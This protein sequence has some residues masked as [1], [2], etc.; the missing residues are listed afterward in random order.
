MSD[1]LVP[2]E[3]PEHFDE[4]LDRWSAAK[5]KCVGWC[6]LCD[7]AIATEADLIP[8][9]DTHNCPKGRALEAASSLEEAKADTKPLNR[10]QQDALAWQII[11]RSQPITLEAATRRRPKDYLELEQWLRDGV[12]FEMAWS[13]FLHAF[14]AAKV[15]SFFA[16]PSP[17]SLSPG[18]QAIVAGSAEW[19]SAEFGLP[20]PAWTDD[21]KYFLDAPW[22]PWQELG[23]DVTDTIEGTLARSPEAFRKRNVAFL[24]RNLIT[25]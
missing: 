9:T 22:D 13:E 4:M 19:L 14:F 21:P 20:H 7:R 3:F 6:L 12:G 11:H 15:A 18:W 25:L 5:D 2:V 23:L 16:H 10:D 17:P 24:S 8:G 1:D